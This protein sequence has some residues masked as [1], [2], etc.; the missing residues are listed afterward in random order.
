VLVACTQRSAPTVCTSRGQTNNIKLHSLHRWWQHRDKKKGSTKE[1]VKRDTCRD[2]AKKRIAAQRT[3][4][5]ISCDADPA[6]SVRYIEDLFKLVQAFTLKR[7]DRTGV[8]RLVLQCQL[9]EAYNIFFFLGILGIANKGFVS[10]VG[11]SARRY[12]SSVDPEHCIAV[13][14]NHWAVCTWTE[15]FLQVPAAGPGAVNW[16][17]LLG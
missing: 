10:Y 14:A 4:E 16:A 12:D 8:N 17:D 6:D 7:G 15:G 3:D 1:K 13:R 11:S 5:C 2:T 9:F